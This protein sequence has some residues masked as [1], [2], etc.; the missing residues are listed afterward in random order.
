MK[1]GDL[2]YL[3]PEYFYEYDEQIGIIVSVDDTVIPTLLH[4]RW[5]D[6]SS[7]IVAADELEVIDEE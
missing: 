7:M 3:N 2:V 1:V 5:M 6:G 4:V